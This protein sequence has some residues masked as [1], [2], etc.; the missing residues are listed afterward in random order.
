MAQD[1]GKGGISDLASLS[2]D[3]GVHASGRHLP[4]PELRDAGR[5]LHHI[6]GNSGKATSILQG[7][8]V[9]QKPWLCF[10]SLTALTS[11]WFEA[12]QHKHTEAH[13]VALRHR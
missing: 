13:V 2:E 3:A 8:P 12:Q 6:P 7:Q 10:A 5:R 4:Y 1:T 9:E 11:G